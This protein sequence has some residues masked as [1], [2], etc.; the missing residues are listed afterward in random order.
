MLYRRKTRFAELEEAFHS[1][2]WFVS[3]VNI[4]PGS[5][6]KIESFGAFVEMNGSRHQGLVR[7]Q[8][9]ITIHSDYMMKDISMMTESM[10]VSNVRCQLIKM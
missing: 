10:P 3:E 5:I 2:I 8:E 4:I 7:L 9:L 1:D 6:V